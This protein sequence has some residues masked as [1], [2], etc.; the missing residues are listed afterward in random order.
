MSDVPTLAYN[1]YCIR[2]AGW[3]T[4]GDAYG[5]RVLIVVVGVTPHQGDG[6][7]VHRAK[8]DR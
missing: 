4:G 2:K 5:H 7:A 6:N 8:Q 1:V 3:P